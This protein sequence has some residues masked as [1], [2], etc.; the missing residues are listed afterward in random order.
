MDLDHRVVSISRNFPLNRT[1]IRF[2][3][4]H[5]RS[6]MSLS[7]QDQLIQDIE[8]ELSDIYIQVLTILMHHPEWSGLVYDTFIHHVKYWINDLRGG[9][10][11]T[12]EETLSFNL[13]DLSIN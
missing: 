13:E 3:V 2:F 1:Y 5:N 6:K 10:Y 9:Q 11:P 8:N 7:T 12:N 4:D